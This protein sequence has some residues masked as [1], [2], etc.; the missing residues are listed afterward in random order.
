MIFAA[1]NLFEATGDAAF[2]DRIRAEWPEKPLDLVLYGS[3]PRGLPL[4]NYLSVALS[5]RPEMPQDLRRQAAA[6]VF[7]VVDG[8]NRLPNGAPVFG[9]VFQG[10]VDGG[11]GWFFSGLRTGFPNLVAWGL[12][13]RAVEET[14][15]DAA[16]PARYRD[17][18]V[19][20]WNY[21]LGA[22]PLSKSHITGLGDPETRVRW[23]V[24][25]LW[26]YQWR[27]YVRTGAGWM[28]PPP[29][30]VVGDLQHGDFGSWFNSSYNAARTK[31]MEPTLKRIPLFYRHTDGWNVTNEASSHTAAMM[32]AIA[33]PFAR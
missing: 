7:Q 11:V 9:I 17:R 3:D 4:Q 25:E 23:P 32:A 30:L 1:A 5:K 18:L 20:C 13:R 14:A 29:G 26:D 33:L 10:A 24:N 31:S 28:E 19:S 12:A 15:M 16:A 2:I 21:L 22:N 8:M 6:W 27:Q